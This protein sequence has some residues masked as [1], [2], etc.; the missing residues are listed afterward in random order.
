MSTDFLLISVLI[1]VTALVLVSDIHSTRKP[2]PTDLNLTATLS[3]ATAHIIRRGQ[4]QF[5]L[6]ETVTRLI[7]TAVNFRQSHSWND[8]MLWYCSD[9][10]EVDINGSWEGMLPWLLALFAWKDGLQHLSAELDLLW[11]QAAVGPNTE[12]FLWLNT[13]R[14]AS[15]SFSNG[16]RT[17]IEQ[18]VQHKQPP[19][20]ELLERE[21]RA[22]RAQ[23][24]DFKQD[25]NDTFQLLIGATAI[26]DSEIQKS[27]A[28]ESK[29][30]AERST[31][32]TAPAAVYLPL[33]LTTGVFGMNISE[34]NDGIPRYWAALL[35]GLGLLA[36]SVPFVLWVFLDKHDE[37]VRL[38]ERPESDQGRRDEPIFE[39]KKRKINA[40]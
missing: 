4:L 15:Q 26:R 22:F 36:I 13:C 21:I 9:Y 34:I 32:L 1:T 31:A 39:P 24:P 5:D 37:D 30:Q 40:W 35:L 29:I 12:D 27:L 38:E 10:G 3:W 6:H 25:F 19:G 8:D 33:S 2:E 14:R 7:G 16:L 18:L 28:R 11:T 23:M 20:K 17:Y